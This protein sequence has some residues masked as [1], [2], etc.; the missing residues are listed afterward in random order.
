MATV[1]AELRELRE[2]MAERVRQ[3]ERARGRLHKLE[4]VVT[5]WLE[6]QKVLRTREE[7]QYRRL[8]TRLQVA[9][10]IIALAALASQIVL[11]IILK[12]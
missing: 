12:A 5:S 6:V 1:E 7:E 10:A 3:E 8:G 9:V 4:G 2:D 11:A